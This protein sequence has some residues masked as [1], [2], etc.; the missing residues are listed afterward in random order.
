MCDASTV[1]TCSGVPT[2]TMSPPSSPPSGPMSISQSA[3]LIDVE[4]VLD[5]E[6]G[7][8][9]VDESLQHLEEL[10]DIG[11]VQPGRRLVEDVE[12]PPGRDLG[13]LRRELDALRL[14]TR[15]RRRRL[16][17]AHVVEAHVVQR[18]QTPRQPRNLREERQRLLDATC[19]G[20]RRSTSLDSAPRASRG[21]SVVPC[22]PRTARTRRAGSASRS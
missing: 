4:V 14:A 22:R 13:E 3:C 1:A 2:A 20:R 5:H 19:R 12:R 15:E 8:A 6:H 21:C 7:V 9:R 16:A 11:D 17:H 10:L 18:L